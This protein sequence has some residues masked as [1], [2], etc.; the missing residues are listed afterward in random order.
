MSGLQLTSL[1]PEWPCELYRSH[2]L[3]STDTAITVGRIDF[4]NNCLQ[5]I[6]KELFTSMFARSLQELV[7]VSNELGGRIFRDPHDRNPLLPPFIKVSLPQLYSI[8]HLYHFYHFY[9]SPLS[10]CRVCCIDTSPPISSYQ[11]P[12]NNHHNPSIVLAPCSSCRLINSASTWRRTSSRRERC[13]TCWRAPLLS[14]CCMSCCHTTSW[15]QSRH[16]YRPIRN[17]ESCR[18]H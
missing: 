8:Y 11:H 7:L 2:S 17:Y 10:L 1:P 5:G 9:L 16:R 3:E 18:L 6:P 14:L 15:M 13:L 4:S 12:Q